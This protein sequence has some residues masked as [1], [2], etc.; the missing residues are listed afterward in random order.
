MPQILKY[1]I[2]PMTWIGAPILL[3]AAVFLGMG[4]RMGHDA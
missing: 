2:G 3:L 4:K 1:E